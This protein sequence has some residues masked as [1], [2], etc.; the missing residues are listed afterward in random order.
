MTRNNPIEKKRNHMVGGLVVLVVGILFLIKN[1][2]I[3]SPEINHYIFS[4]KTLLIGIG[5]ANILLT[6]NKIGG[7]ILIAIG[8][9]FWM[10]EW[11][12]LS[13]R[14]SQIFW[15]SV[16][17]LIGVMLLLKK[18]RAHKPS[19]SKRKWE[20]AN[21]KWRKAENSDNQNDPHIQE[22]K[23]GRED[24]FVDDLAIFSGNSKI[25]NSQ[26]F[27]GGK[28]SA[29]FGGSELNLTRA[30]LAPGRNVLQILFVFGGA[31]IIVPSD[32]NIVIEVSPIF[33]SLSDERYVSSELQTDENS[34]KLLIIRGL[35]LFGGAEIK[36]Y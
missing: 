35:V 4:W 15:P 21:D 36:S 25:V 7:I 27:K 18:P 33:G 34:D 3:M 22:N 10:P 20:K 1:L 17:I 12:D 11:F 29:I 26:N 14:A 23:H 32:W 9:F 6:D 24:E 5:V 13:V 19:F 31:E 28:L 30:R 16:I 2:H 8:S